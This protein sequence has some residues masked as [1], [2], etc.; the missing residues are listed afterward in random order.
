LAR[1]KDIIQGFVLDAGCGNRPFAIWYDQ[2]AERS[3]GL[4]VLAL[5]GV[6]VVGYA[7]RLPLADHVFDTVLATE[8][9]EHVGDAEQAVAD[10]F[11]V[12]RPGGHL[13]VT[14]PFLYPTHEAPYDF[15][16]FTHH[17]LR[18]L[19]ERHGFEV[20]EVE[21][22]GGAVSLLLHALVLSLVG[23]IDA[24]G[25][26]LRIPRTSRNVVVRTVIAGPQEILI[27][28]QSHL[29]ER[30]GVRLSATRA[31]LGYMAVARRP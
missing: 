7:D 4:D 12:L 11:R 8:V 24:V 6:G 2:L 10:F 18:S 19:L 23:L 17:G 20:V 1:N 16:R 3:L 14:V 25:K 13:L 9:L 27:W 31:S 15:R 21:A 5:P 28:A 30:P 22:K 29:R 26:V